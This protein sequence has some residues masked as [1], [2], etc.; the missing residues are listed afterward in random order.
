MPDASSMKVCVLTTSYPTTQDTTRGIFVSQLYSHLKQQGVHFSYLSPTIFTPLT[1]GA[2]IFSNLQTSWSARLLFP[3]YALV[4]FLQILFT[5]RRYDLLHANWSLTAFLALL[6]KPMHR[7][8]ILLTERSSHLIQLT[9]PFLKFFIRYT[10]RHVD[11]LVTLSKT[12]RQ[13]LSNNYHIPLSSILVIPN[14]VALPTLRP[15]PALR[16]R[17]HLSQKTLLLTVGRLT[18]DK[19]YATLLLALH[20][21]PKSLSSYHLLL[22]GDG[23]AKSSL[24]HLVQQY[25]LSSHVTFLGKISHDR[26]YD[27]MAASDIFV[28]TSLKDSGGN[29]ILESMAH[30]LALVSTPVGWAKDYLTSGRNGL[31]FTPQD[32]KNLTK[33]LSHLLQQLQLR[34]TL[35]QAA[36]QTIVREHLTWN[37]CAKRY[38]RL[39]KELLS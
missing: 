16:K 8:K 35:G 5:A 38:L 20:H 4:F 27:Y 2:G 10:Y 37:H 15:Q 7:K 3:L 13:Q 36:R 23:E 24:E 21:L 31:F 18:R 19:D 9:N 12:A 33:H 11:I 14:G 29:V 26:V 28:Q 34:K 1:S 30:G 32:T 25:G 22:I 6:A 39:Y 17:L